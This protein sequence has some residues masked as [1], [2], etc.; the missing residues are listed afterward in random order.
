MPGNVQ[1]DCAEAAVKKELRAAG[2]ELRLVEKQLQCAERDEKLSAFQA[3]AVQIFAGRAKAHLGVRIIVVNVF[4]SLAGMFIIIVPV[5][6]TFGMASEQKAEAHACKHGG[7]NQQP[8]GNLNKMQR[9]P[10]N[11]VEK[12]QR[13]EYPEIIAVGCAVNDQRGQQ[14]RSQNADEPNLPER[15][16]LACNHKDRRK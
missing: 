6:L 8:Q 16:D 13:D 12:R 1:F 2:A 4:H 3:V 7:Q 5:H 9:L 14:N 10:V 15:A 11:H